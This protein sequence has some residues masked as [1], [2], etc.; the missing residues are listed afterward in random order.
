M[1]LA[2][3]TTVSGL[4]KGFTSESLRIIHESLGSIQNQRMVDQPYHVWN[5]KNPSNNHF[6]SFWN[7]GITMKNLGI[8]VNSFGDLKPQSPFLLKLLTPWPMLRE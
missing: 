2:I 8:S 5:Y 6:E 4:S 1:A 3:N 7:L